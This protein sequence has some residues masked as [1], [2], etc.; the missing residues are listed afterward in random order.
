VKG[1]S[2]AVLKI[3]KSLVAWV[4][5]LGTVMGPVHACLVVVRFPVFRCFGKGTNSPG[6]CTQLPWILATWDEDVSKPGVQRVPLSFC[7]VANCLHQVGIYPL[8]Q[9]ILPG[10]SPLPKGLPFSLNLLN[11]QDT[12]ISSIHISFSSLVFGKMLTSEAI[13]WVLEE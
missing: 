1:L 3:R 6:L 2:C 11:L 7:K 8:P 10:F 13:R 5:F 4:F 12:R 9:M